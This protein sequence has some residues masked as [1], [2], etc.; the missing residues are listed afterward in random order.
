MTREQLLEEI[1]RLRDE[2]ERYRK[3]VE[4]SPDTVAIHRGGKIEYINP[5]GAKLLGAESPEQ[6]IGRSIADFVHPDFRQVVAERVRSIVAEGETEV[7]FAE[8]KL[9]SLDG[10]AIDVEA[11]GVLF[12]D[13][14][15]PVVQTIVRDITERKSAEERIRVETE[16][17]QVLLEG[18]AQAGI[19]INIVNRE[20]RVEF[21][22]RWLEEQFPGGTGRSCFGTYSANDQPCPGC[23]LQRAL[24]TGKAASGEIDTRDGRSFLVFATPLSTP[25]GDPDRAIEVVVDVTERRLA[26]RAVGEARERLVRFMDAA[27]DAFYLLDADLRFVEVNRR[28]LAVAGCGREEIIGKHIGE[29]VPD[30]RGSGRYERHRR[31]IETGEPFEIDLFVPHPRFGDRVIALKSFKVGDGLGVIATDVTE[32]KQAEAALRAER[33]RAQNYLDIAGVIMVAINADET[34]ELVNRRGSEVLGGKAEE[35]VGSNWFDRFIPSDERETVREVFGK[36][37]RGEIEPVE[38]FENRVRTAAGE[39]RVISWHNTVLYDGQGDIAGT[40]SSGEDVTDRRNAEEA[41]RRSEELMRNV[42]ETAPDG[43]TTTDLEGTIIYSSPAAARIYGVES[44]DE[45]TGLNAFE[46]FVPEDRERAMQDMLVALE[47][48]SLLGREFRLLRAD[49]SSYPAEVSAGVLRDATGAPT[50]IVAI[51]RDVTERK[52]AEEALRKSE[53]AFRTIA[54]RS[55]DV[56]FTLDVEGRITYCSPALVD[57]LGHLPR[58]VTDVRVIDFVDSSEVEAALVTLRR[59]AGGESVQPF[60]LPVTHRDGHLVQVEVRAEPISHSGE[61]SGIQGVMHD[62]TER[63]Q[64]EDR[65]RSLASDLSLA[66]EKERRRIAVEL[67]DQVGQTLAL[68]NLKL[69]VLREEAEPGELAARLD[70]IRNYWQTA[71]AYTRS[72]TADLSPPVLYE[73][74]LE[75]A[76]EWLVER[77]RA[78]HEDLVFGFTDDG[79]P[80]PVDEDVRIVLFQAV[81]ELLVNVVKHAEATSAAVTVSRVGDEVRVQVKDDGV[82]FDAQALRPEGIEFGL[83]SIRERLRS[84]GGT[85]EIESRP[86]VG[87]V[88]G[89][90]APLVE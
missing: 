37:M 71:M 6:L 18:L 35:I 49:G 27:S 31:V 55:I 90:C 5:A 26:G 68:A 57:V 41:L 85:V 83:Y 60:V 62:V 67:H 4:M 87:T 63:Q 23:P 56:I 2:L 66:E 75:A 42:L 52:R 54:E 73:L 11:G 88:V 22:N 29:V 3:L 9:V 70:E 33:D 14:G 65:L 24:A 69:G 76:L 79:S 74:G 64:W 25:H 89:L 40:L 46:F 13:D 59:F 80:K 82:G 77:Q 39:Q 8:E 28:G 12:S 72:L 50:G 61:V 10:R 45:L 81:R 51:F 47:Q 1:E 58:D 48:G 36:L 19:G 20:L 15:E 32:R 34:I 78:L 17:L 44:P 16:K 30:V 21:Q 86:G 53:E 84:L 43:V 38:Y 7:P